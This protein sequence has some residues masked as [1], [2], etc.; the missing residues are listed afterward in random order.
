MHI[1]DVISS[2]VSKCI[3]IAAAGASPQTSTGG[4]T[5]SPDSL[6][7]FKGAYFEDPTSKVRA[8]K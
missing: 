3:K 1:L 8:P 4:L 7:G 2:V 6:A 5:A